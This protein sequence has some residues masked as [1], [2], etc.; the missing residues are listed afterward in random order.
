MVEVYNPVMQETLDEL[1]ATAGEGSQV[2]V[3]DQSLIDQLYIANIFIIAIFL[4]LALM[5]ID[6]FKR[7]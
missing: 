6:Q 5:A 2:M 7:R 4:L 1:I 3:V